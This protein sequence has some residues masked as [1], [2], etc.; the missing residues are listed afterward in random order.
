MTAILRSLF[1]KVTYTCHV[2]G[3][4]QRIPLR[5]VHVFERFHRLEQGEPLL[6]ACPMCSE[7]LQVPSRYHTHTGHMVDITAHTLPDNA[8]IHSSY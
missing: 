3:A 8:V 5:R 1:R 2:C 6:I 4:G 7:G